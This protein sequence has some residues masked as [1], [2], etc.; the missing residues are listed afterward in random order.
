MQR[1]TI[2]HKAKA[3]SI[4]SAFPMQQQKNIRLIKKNNEK[5]E[6]YQVIAQTHMGNDNAFLKIKLET[7]T[8]PNAK[9]HCKARVN[10]NY[11]ECIQKLYDAGK[12]IHPEYKID[13]ERFNDENG[14]CHWNINFLSNTQEKM[15]TAF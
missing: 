5:G 2:S 8:K 11:L 15:H 3:D 1:N 12:I 14:Q 6:F 7:T 10:D 9:V 4:V 13:T